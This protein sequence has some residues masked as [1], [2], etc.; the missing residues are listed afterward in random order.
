MSVF[1]LNGI[2]INIEKLNDE[3]DYVYYQRVKK[4]LKNINLFNYKLEEIIKL[5][6]LWSNIKYKKCKYNIEI[7]DK[8]DK[9]FKQN[10]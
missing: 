1:I 2:L 10:N 7:M 3:S 9:L 8:V 4:I 6:I 5:S